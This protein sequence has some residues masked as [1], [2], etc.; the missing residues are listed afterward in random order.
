MPSVEPSL[1]PRPM[2][3]PSPPPL[4]PVTMDWAVQMGFAKTEYGQAASWFRAL[5]NIHL[6]AGLDGSPS[7]PD[8]GNQRTFLRPSANAAESR[9]AAGAKARLDP[10]LAEAEEEI[11]TATGH[12][13]DLEAWPDR[14]FPCE[15]R[16]CTVAE[17]RQITDELNLTIEQD[18]NNRHFHHERIAQWWKVLATTLLFADLVAFVVILADMFNIDYADPLAAPLLTLTAY[19]VPTILVVVQWFTADRAG[20]R[21]N[22]YREKSKHAGDDVAPLLRAAVRW[23]LIAGLIAATYSGLLMARLLAMGREAELGVPLQMIFAL[24]GIAVG[25]GA[26]LTKVYVVAE[27]GSSTSRRRDLFAA[28]LDEQRELWEAAVQEA[29]DALSQ[30]AS[31]HEEYSAR[32][33]PLVLRKAGEPLV[34]A[35]NGLGLL[36]VML[37]AGTAADRLDPAAERGRRSQPVGAAVDNPWLPLLRWGFE[38]APE[39]NNEQLSTRDRT[40]CGQLAR[41]STL[42]ARMLDQRTMRTEQPAHRTALPPTSAGAIRELAAAPAD[43]ATRAGQPGDG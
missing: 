16:L 27:D 39:I 9:L 33:R 42:R 8:T 36:N 22:E 7:R 5:W 40:Y 15:G 6:L 13:D 2:P 3:I 26:P 17:A 12:I 1:P 23:G 14:E 11:G 34:E 10:C 41:A 18:T 31:L 38:N 19:V 20:R 35:E 24:L 32:L 30:A 43:G 25:L 37:G 4:P 29:K 21:L 28:A